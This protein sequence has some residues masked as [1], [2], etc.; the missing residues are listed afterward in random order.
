LHIRLANQDRRSLDSR[1]MVFVC[2]NYQHIRPKFDEMTD[3]D[4]IGVLSVDLVP[5]PKD[6]FTIMEHLYSVDFELLLEFQTDISYSFVLNGMSPAS[7][8]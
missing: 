7:C 1:I 3:C 2:S 8:P 4:K 6:R 5:L